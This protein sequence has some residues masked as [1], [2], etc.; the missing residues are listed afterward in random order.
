[1]TVLLSCK[2]LKSDTDEI[3][4]SLSLAAESLE[5][6]DLKIWIGLYNVYFLFLPSIW[7]G[8]SGSQSDPLGSLLPEDS[9][10]QLGESS[11]TTDSLEPTQIKIPYNLSRKEYF[12]VT[13]PISYFLK[14]FQE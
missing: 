14:S 9:S 8:C 11:T 2:E 10:V 12:S 13:F 7:S 5:K 6:N 4:L 3:D 1:M